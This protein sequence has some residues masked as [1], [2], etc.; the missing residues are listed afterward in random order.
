MVSIPPLT[1]PEGRAQELQPKCVW[2]NKTQISL[3]KQ[4]TSSQGA[5]GGDREG[6]ETQEPAGNSSLLV[7]AI[8]LA[9]LPSSDKKSW[10]DTVR[11]KETKCTA[12]NSTVN[13][14]WGSQWPYSAPWDLSFEAG[15]ETAMEETAFLIRAVAA[16][17]GV[18]VPSH[19]NGFCQVPRFPWAAPATFRWGHTGAALQFAPAAQS[20][21]GRQNTVFA[22]WTSPF[23]GPVA[24]AIGYE[25]YYSRER[26][27]SPTQS[28]GM[29]KRWVAQPSSQNG[30]F[31]R[32]P[33]TGGD[34]TH[35]G[36]CSCSSLEQEAARYQYMWL[37]RSKGIKMES[38]I[39]PCP[40]M[41][42][43]HNY[44]ASSG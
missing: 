42:S 18:P 25:N 16:L 24:A 5:E 38:V 4:Q 15:E 40:G 17:Q 28:C 26:S 27:S 30:D 7:Q 43:S 11:K 23:S 44:S 10:L 21:C 32:P 9:N 3:G 2:E 6:G 14:A 41:S 8:T 36:S 35:M 31:S 1:T 12:G 34:K 33:A 39:L 37:G 29:M 13:T 20:H 22:V 19:W